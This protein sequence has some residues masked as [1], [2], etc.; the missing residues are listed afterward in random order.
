MYKNLSYH[1]T[2]HLPVAADASSSCEDILFKAR[3]RL[4]LFYQDC[5]CYVLA[6]NRY[7]L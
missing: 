1:V 4:I 5:Y 6:T 7:T 2:S 3:G